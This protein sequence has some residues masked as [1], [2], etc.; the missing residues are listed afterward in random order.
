MGKAGKQ[1]EKSGA[2]SSFRNRDLAYKIS[3]A[4]GILL[5]GCL[6]L[7]IAVSAVLVANSMNEKVNGEFE[8]IATQNGLMVQNTI[9]TASDTATILQDYILSKYDEYETD[10]YS[11]E[12]KRSEVYNIEL[13][14][15][16]KEME[17]FMLSVARSAA[18]STDGI[19]G[20]GIFFEPNA[21]DPAIK[22][23]TI[24]VSE[25]DAAN[26]SVQSY[27]SYD[28]YGAQDYY[29][30]AAESQEN[31]FT[32]PYEDQGINMVSASFPIVH[33][34]ETEGVILVDINI[35][36]FSELRSSDENYP[37]M[38]VDV[39]NPQGM[40][41]Y[42]SESDTYVGQLLKTMIPED[43][44]AK[45]KAGVQTGESFHV[46]TKKD[47]GS[48][49]MRYYAPLTAAGQTW[50]TASALSTSD[51]YRSTFMLVVIMII[52]AVITLVV[53]IYISTR[54][55]RR[56]ILP[57]H[58]V[59]AGAQQLAQG[60]FSVS[61]QTEYHD[62]IGQL[63]ET[64][65]D[66]AVRLRAIIQNFSRA[67]NQMA[68]GNFNLV[69]K[70]KNVGDFKGM[71]TALVTVLHDMSKTLHEI[72]EVSELVASNA[73]QISEGAQSLTDGATDQANSVDELQSTIMNVTEQVNKNAENANGANEMAKLVGQEI[74]DSNEQMQRVVHAMEI[75]NESSMQISSIINTINDIAGQTNLLALNASIEAAR[76]GEAGR[77]FA[78]VATQVGNL[79]AESAE[80]AK[81]SSGL[82][83][84]TMHA[85][86]E[87]KQIVDS[88]AAKLL[89]SVDKTNELVENIAGI[90]AASI[91]QSTAL[92]QISEAANQIAAVVEENTAMAEESSA[93]SEELAAQAE[94]LKELIRVFQ[95]QDV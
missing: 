61:I 35:D 46:S 63:A 60:D 22:D 6:T 15:L 93:S 12:T 67:L 56:Y 17:E 78:V 51:L 64:F 81:S 24:Y 38:Y 89:E 55:T 90:S 25:E 39:L 70:G 11:G 88:A 8:G 26:G 5:V 37:S 66:M 16:N 45:I 69:P 71:E 19:A 42:D 10:G 75:I 58:D 23:Y 54:L 79:A 83:I 50:W 14:M 72:N 28:S 84:Q 57:I 73:A 49:V 80:A 7:M 20:V 2:V 47:D 34:G 48:K 43:D 65:T 36:T 21:F 85:V 76:A 41:I 18:L 1:K 4:T 53:I 86:E 95:L 3:V 62:E 59:M 27:G 33:D 92:S 32:D 40:I 82:I 30:N 9:T 13:Q 31:C 94:K 68:A 77:G 87:G 52:I 91:D 29:K 74:A 44:Y